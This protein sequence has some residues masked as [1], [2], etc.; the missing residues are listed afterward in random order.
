MFFTRFCFGIDFRPF[1]PPF[2]SALILAD[3]A[4]I[5]CFSKTSHFPTFIDQFS[6][7]LFPKIS[8]FNNRKLLFNTLFHF[9]QLFIK[10]SFE[11]G[12]FFNFYY[13]SKEIM[14]NSKKLSMAKNFKCHFLMPNGYPHK[15]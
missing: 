8:S 1:S 3:F 11:N 13:I 10:F 15:K 12:N 6:K 2:D 14:A 4:Q 7:F 9:E 5:E